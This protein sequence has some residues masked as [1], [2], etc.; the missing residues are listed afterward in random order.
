MKKQGLLY[1][2]SGTKINAPDPK[3]LERFK[4]RS[5]AGKVVPLKLWDGQGVVLRICREKWA[6]GE[7]A[8]L[9][10]YRSVQS[11]VSTLAIAL[12]A[13]N[14]VQGDKISIVGCFNKEQVDY[15]RGLLARMMGERLTQRKDGVLFIGNSF[16][17]ISTYDKV[18]RFMYGK[19]VHGMVCFDSDYITRSEEDGFVKGL[20][21]AFSL[22][23]P[24]FY[25]NINHRDI[26][27]IQWPASFLKV[28]I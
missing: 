11:G 14:L 1:M 7:P 27:G 28:E 23:P 24:C 4:I 6:L 3:S 22:V 18:P 8:W 20:K 26:R 13:W 16:A 25:L 15:Y 10:I 19:P 21:S 17:S 5:H 12:V 9:D 2:D